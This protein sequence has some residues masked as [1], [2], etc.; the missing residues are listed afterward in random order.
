MDKV[1]PI[2]KDSNRH[3]S[4]GDSD[5]NHYVDLDVFDNPSIKGRPQTPTS[6]QTSSGSASANVYY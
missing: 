2:R 6:T 3:N 5:F 4:K 1:N